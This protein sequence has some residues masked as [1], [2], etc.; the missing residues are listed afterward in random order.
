MPSSSMVYLDLTNHVIQLRTLS[1][2]VL[3]CM[4]NQYPRNGPYQTLLMR[5][6]RPNTLSSSALAWVAEVLNMISF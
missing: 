4:S 6:I 1:G 2:I 3:W 5:P